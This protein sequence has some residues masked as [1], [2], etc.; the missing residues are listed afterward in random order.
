MSW[1]AMV[2]GWFH[3]TKL[4]AVSTKPQLLPSPCGTCL[5]GPNPDDVVYAVH[6]NCAERMVLMHNTHH[7]VHAILQGDFPNTLPLLG[8]MSNVP[9]TMW[10]LWRTEDQ[11][12]LAMDGRRD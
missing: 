5:I 1:Y 6:E 8:A 11:E 9:S 12:R 4:Q 2:C 7:T 10:L 3:E